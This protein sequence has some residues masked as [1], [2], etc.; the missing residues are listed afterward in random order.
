MEQTMETTIIKKPK[1]KSNRQIAVALRQ[2][3]RNRLAMAGLVVLIIIILLCSLESI[4]TPFDYSV[5]DISNRFSKISLQHPCGTDRFGRDLFTRILKGGQISLLVASCSVLLCAVSAAV[6]GSTAAFF[7]G[8]YE[9]VVMRT[10]DIL[11]GIPS[12]LLAAAVSTALGKGIY[13]SVIAIALAQL[14]N[15]TRIMYSSALT[16]RDKEYLE[17]ARATGASNLRLVFKYIVPDCLAPLIVQISLRLGICITMIS[18]LSFIGLGVQPPTPEWGSILNE[19]RQFIR[20][21]WPVVTFPGIAIA[22]TLIS[23]NLVGDG[24]RDALDPRMKH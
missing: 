6:L 11:M 10:M 9:T 22:L 18:S 7:G 23:V 14:A 3:K 2:F 15:M 19:G 4:I 24:V 8:V 16:I 17:A 21:Y 5:Q 13:N 12:L 20:Q 1:G